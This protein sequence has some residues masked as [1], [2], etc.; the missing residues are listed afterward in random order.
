MQAKDLFPWALQS[1]SHNIRASTL[2]VS[3]P[4]QAV[5]PNHTRK[6]PK[7]D[8][9]QTRSCKPRMAHNLGSN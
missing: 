4:G 9:S 3:L 2:T 6:C 1:V 8:L 7:K 5:S